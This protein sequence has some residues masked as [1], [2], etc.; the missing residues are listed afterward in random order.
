[1][2]RF[3]YTTPTL[4]DRAP[5]DWEPYLDTEKEMA[6]PPGLHKESMGMISIYVPQIAMKMV[7][8]SEVL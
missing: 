1:M 2:Y 5:Y 6:L 4:P 7:K 3:H 8:I